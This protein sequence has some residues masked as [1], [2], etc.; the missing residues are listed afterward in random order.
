MYEYKYLKLI[1][2]ILL[3]KTIYINIIVIKIVNKKYYINIFILMIFPPEDNIQV[4]FLRFLILLMYYGVY[5][6]ISAI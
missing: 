3:I 1:F 5:I 4:I 2:R 6:T